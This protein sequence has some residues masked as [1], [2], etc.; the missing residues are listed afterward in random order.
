MPGGPT[1]ALELLRALRLWGDTYLWAL[2]HFFL[3]AELMVGI[4]FA[5]GAILALK[6]VNSLEECTSRK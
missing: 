2:G 3:A 1:L 4:W 5:V 6:M